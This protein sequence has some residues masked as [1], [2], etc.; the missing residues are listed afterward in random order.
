MMTAVLPLTSP[1]TF[2]TSVRSSLPRRRFSTIAS[3]ADRS[4]AK[5]RAF[6]AKPSSLTTTMSSSCLALMCA[7]MRLTAVSSSTGMLKNPWIWPW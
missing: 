7:Q 3:G 6:F 5:F 2:I 1:M 4:S